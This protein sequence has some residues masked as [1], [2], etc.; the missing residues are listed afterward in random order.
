MKLLIMYFM[1][2]YYL[3]SVS[4]EYC[5]YQYILRI[6]VFNEWSY[7]KRPASTPVLRNR[8]NCS[9]VYD[10]LIFGCQVEDRKTEVY[11]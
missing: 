6:S 2:S 10:I 5:S 11:D 9:F 1:H 8:Q 3:M 4:S 7:G